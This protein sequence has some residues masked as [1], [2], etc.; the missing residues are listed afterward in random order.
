MCVHMWEDENQEKEVKG[1]KTEREREMSREPQTVATAM[2]IYH[3]LVLV[4]SQ[5][6]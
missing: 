2:Q 4:T 6:P 1:E 3:P 5:P